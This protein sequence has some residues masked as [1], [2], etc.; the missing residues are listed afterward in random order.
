ME[1]HQLRYFVAVAKEG[2][3]SRAARDLF[4]SQ[5]SLSTQI[6]K[7][8]QH[9]GAE[10]FERLARRVVLTSAGEAFL[11][12]AE[13]VLAELEAGRD[14]VADVVG[15]RHGRVSVGV[16]PSVA[17]YL[18]PSV[19]A[20]FRNAHPGVRIQLVE[21]DVSR[22]FEHLVRAGELDLAITRLPMTVSGLCSIRLVREPILLLVPPEHQLGA[23]SADDPVPLRALA[24]E[25]F[26]SMR[27]GYGLR[28]LADQLCAGAGF[29]PKVVLET[30]QL[31][32][33]R[34]MVNAGMGV[35]LLPRLA[36]GGE[37]SV[38]PITEPA[39][40]RELGVLW[41]ASSMASPPVAA[42]LDALRRVAYGRHSSPAIPFG[43]SEP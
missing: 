27:A 9:L 21:H 18:L 22:E 3:I 5:P 43:P 2:S 6:R 1:L 32:I 41:R 4:L 40:C 16:L 8:E 12:H 24:D 10:L 33:V 29:T 26:V 39:A 14:R 25:E 42:F 19:V 7:L 20:A 17:A 31:S 11:E 30:G 37:R 38:V 28:E 35:A 23:R 15:V 13:R 36:A 34:G